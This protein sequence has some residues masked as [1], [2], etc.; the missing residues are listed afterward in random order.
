MWSSDSPSQAPQEQCRRLCLP[1][2]ACR[3]CATPSA[4]LSGGLNGGPGDDCQVSTGQ[5]STYQVSTYQVSTY[6]VSTYQVS[7]YHVVTT[8]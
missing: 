8:R 1:L 3:I 7:T 6:Q 4:C 5:V 2:P